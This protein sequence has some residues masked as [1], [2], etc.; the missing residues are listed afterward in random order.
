MIKTPKVSVYILVFN[1]A[2][3]V[4]KAIRSVLNQVFKD[5]ELIVINDGSTDGTEKILRKYE[6]YDKVTIVN[7]A[8]KGLAGSCNVA[9]RLASG[10]YIIRL[11][12]DDY[13]EENALLVM[14][15]FLDE[16]PN[17]GL[18]YPDYYL[19][20]EHDDVISIERREKINGTDWKLKD[21][22]PHGACTVFR[23]NILLEL[24]MYDEEISCQDGY[25][26]WIRFIE[27]YKA[28]NINLPLF[29]YRQHKDSLTK[30]NEKILDTRQ[31][32]KN[33]H[34]NS[35]RKRLNIA[36]IR[37]VAIIPARS[38]S[39]VMPRMA[40][41]EFAGRPMIDWTIDETLKS[42]SFNRVVVVS[43]DSE[44][45]NYT[46]ENYTSITAIERPLE[47]ARRNTGL[48]KTVQL[49]LDTLMKKYGE[50]YQEG[51]LLS[52]ESPLKRSNHFIK[53]ID[54]MHIFE[55]DNV[56][57][58]CETNSPYYVRSGNSLKRVGNTERFRLER[59]T[60][61][62][63]NGALCL[64]KTKN[65]SKGSIFGE[66]T[67]QIIMLKEDSLNIRSSFDYEVAE[68][69]LSR[70]NDAAPPVK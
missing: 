28:D 29:Y 34:A 61:Y 26:I 14:T 11:D 4:E 56:I 30:N 43:E 48:E 16:H 1:Y 18:V 25:D 13:L 31:K 15:H 6:L 46:K 36:D 19:V 39:D 27:N 69:L 57:S 62:R 52:V 44:I 24:G 37:R 65:L 22:P 5:W 35:K 60:I 55:T 47:Y 8:N 50:E 3:Y 49:V 59:K 21:A 70:R 64:F 10:E 20:D 9:L 67:G 54:T 33:K 45:L 68:F 12:G 17:I 2:K 53:A 23:R 51:M 7:Q 41:Q 58:L 40:L 32:I 42:D 63:D 66:K 38:H